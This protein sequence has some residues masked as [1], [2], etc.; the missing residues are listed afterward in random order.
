ME[1]SSL[2]FVTVPQCWGSRF[3]VSLPPFNPMPSLWYFFSYDPLAFMLLV[4]SLGNR[5]GSTDLFI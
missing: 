2:S 1:I 5:I 4:S 3:S